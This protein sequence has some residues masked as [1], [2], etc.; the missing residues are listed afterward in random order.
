MAR[1]RS[2]KPGFFRSA[3]VAEL[4]SDACRI[5]WIGLWTYCD[6]YGRGIDDSRLV[7]GEIWALHDRVTAKVVEGHL[8]DLADSEDPMICRYEMGGRRY[9]HVVNWRLHQ[10]INRPT[11][12][13]I[14]PCPKHE[15]PDPNG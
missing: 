1:I 3:S 12:S 15:L 9:L 14:P 10:K 6:D 4:S 11:P 8:V 7:K 13:V 2:I 5:T